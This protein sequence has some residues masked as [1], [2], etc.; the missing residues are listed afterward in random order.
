MIQKAEVD[1]TIEDIHQ[2]RARLA[3]KFGGDIK[4]ILEDT[5]KRQATSGHPIW[6]G[7]QANKTMQQSLPEASA[8]E[9]ELVTE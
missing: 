1:T 5:R 8:H 7:T 6:I 3:E 9:N 2:I 4:A